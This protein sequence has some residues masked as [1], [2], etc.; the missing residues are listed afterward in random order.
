MQ[1]SLRRVLPKNYTAVNSVASRYFSSSSQSNGAEVRRA[2]LENGVT[3][4]A[5]PK[6]NDTLASAGVFV[7]AGSA[8][9]NHSTHG[10]AHYL[11]RFLYK[12]TNR[13]SG[14]RITRSIE[15]VTASFAAENTPESLM[16]RALFQHE[17]LGTALAL[18]GDV[19]RPRL[20][21]WE[22][23]DVRNLVKYDVNERKSN[24]EDRVLDA[25]RHTAFGGVG[26]GRSPLCPEHNINE[27]YPEHVAE[28]TLGRVVGSNITVVGNVRD[29]EKF[30]EAVANAFGALPKDPEV[31][32]DAPETSPYVGGTTLVCDGPG[33]AYVEA[34]S[35]GSSNPKAAFA[36]QILAEILGFYTPHNVSPSDRVSSRLGKS[37][38]GSNVSQA[39]TFL[40]NDS[41]QLFGIQAF[42][43]TP[44]RDLAES[45]HKQLTSLADNISEEEFNTAM[46]IVSVRNRLRNDRREVLLGTVARVDENTAKEFGGEVTASDVRDVAK[47]L[48][49][50]KPTIYASGDLAQLPKFA[51]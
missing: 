11:R 14:L 18:M 34:Y 23:R 15:T 8:Y 40:M 28:Y 27:I 24:K 30:Q 29:H 6:S 19:L 51:F 38:V 43:N 44:C 49:E 36:Q 2:V 16:Y 39:R 22:F 13:V 12:S 46:N 42:G 45:V 47:K 33:S 32:I 26:L 5:G 20:A 17:H 31:S 41:Q 50:S 10:C 7:K 21:E 48:L 9:E 4:I 3:I 1:C 37:L 35:T 25:V